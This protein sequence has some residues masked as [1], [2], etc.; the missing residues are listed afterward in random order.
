MSDCPIFAT[1]LA[2]SRLE[3]EIDALV[4]EFESQLSSEDTGKI[5]VIRKNSQWDEDEYRYASHRSKVSVGGSRGKP[6]SRWLTLHFDLM[7]PQESPLL[8]AHAS[9]ALLIV[10]YCSDAGEWYSAKGLAVLSS[11]R[12]ENQDVWENVS[13][14]AAIENK[15]LVWDEGGDKKHTDWS[16]QNVS[17]EDWIFGAVLRQVTD[18]DAIKKMLVLPVA[19][20]LLG[21]TPAQVFNGTNAIKWE[22]PGLPRGKTI[23]AQAIPRPS[24]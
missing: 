2:A 8:W 18:S 19:S 3:T 7:R 22:I 21:K 20:L 14:S 24:V 17:E 16:Q 1:Y 15:L 12:L 4:D 10:A 11:G 23:A 13:R 5:T 6:R 9:D